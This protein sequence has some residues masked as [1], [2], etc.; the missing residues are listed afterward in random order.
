M[1][2]SG[3]QFVALTLLKLKSPAGECIF[4]ITPLAN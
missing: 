3:E 1:M 4:M 2:D